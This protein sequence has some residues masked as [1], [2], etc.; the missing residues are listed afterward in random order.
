MQMWFEDFQDSHHGG[1]LGYRNG[2]ILAILN[3]YFA[4]MLPSNFDSIQLTVW[5]E[6]LFKEFQD[7]GCGSYL[8]YWNGRI[9]AI[10]TQS[11]SIPLHAG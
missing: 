3:L 11:V 6:M 2:T 7:G 8:G 1:H 9:L 5:E 10:L 4:L